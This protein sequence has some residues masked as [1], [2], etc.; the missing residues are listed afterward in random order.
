MGWHMILILIFI[1]L[2]SANPSAQNPAK[3]PREGSCVRL[4]PERAN[5][6]WSYDFVKAM[7]HD[8][9]GLRIAGD[10]HDHASGI[11]TLTTG[12][13]DPVEFS[14]VR[15]VYGK[16]RPQCGG[17]GRGRAWLRR[18]MSLRNGPLS[19]QDYR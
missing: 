9:R 17:G 7:T 19:K 18:R 16:F 8:G 3:S 4:R 12:R 1:F 14:A 13:T 5:H 2:L 15:I 11:A 10:C 6:V